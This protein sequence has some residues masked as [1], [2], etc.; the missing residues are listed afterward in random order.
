MWDVA[1]D[2]PSD[3]DRLAAGGWREVPTA[4][5][6]AKAAD[7]HFCVAVVNTDDGNEANPYHTIIESFVRA[8]DG[9][10]HSLGH[11]G[12]LGRG[13]GDG[14]YSSPEGSMTYEYGWSE[15]ESA[16]WVVVAQEL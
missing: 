1:V 7:G 13:S 3:H 10:W 5:V 15:S 14:S 16:W 4:C 12:P 9:R 11:H 2:V 6:L 8:P